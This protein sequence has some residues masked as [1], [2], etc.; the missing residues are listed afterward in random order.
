MTHN[1]A[2]DGTAR[3]DRPMET[4]HHQISKK[5][6]NYA[7]FKGLPTLRTSKR[8]VLPR[9]RGPRGKVGGPI[10]LKRPELSKLSTRREKQGTYRG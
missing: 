9:E 2:T 6:K 7:P 1:V 3:G 5:E 8:H 4:R 10:S